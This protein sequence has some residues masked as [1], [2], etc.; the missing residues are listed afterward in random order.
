M[1]RTFSSCSLRS[2]WCTADHNVNKLLW[3]WNLAVTLGTS[4]REEDFEDCTTDGLPGLGFPKGKW[5]LDTRNPASME[6]HGGQIQYVLGTMSKTFKVSSHRS[7]SSGLGTKLGTIVNLAGAEMY[8]RLAPGMLGCHLPGAIFLGRRRY[9][10][11]LYRGE[12]SCA[13]QICSRWIL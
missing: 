1:S 8:L 11:K 3:S 13:G 4:Q 10:L 6:S 9:F 7:P 12:M 5:L 2:T